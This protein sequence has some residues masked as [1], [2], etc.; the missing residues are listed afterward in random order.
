[1]VLIAAAIAAMSC[2]IQLVGT[3]G[4]GTET[5]PDG[6]TPDAPLGVSE[7]GAAA[8]PDGGVSVADADADAPAC[9]FV[10]IVDP[11]TSLD[12]GDGGWVVARDTSNGDHPKIDPSA[13]GPAVSLI[14]L[15]AVSS[16]GGI[17]RSP[18]DVRAFDMSFRYIITCGALATC[19]DG[20]AAM[21][22]QSRDGGP[23]ELFPSLSGSTFGMPGPG[24]RGGAV[25][26]DVHKDLGTND[27]STPC[28]SI[29]S[30]DP[31][32]SP[33]TYDWHVA[34]TPQDAGLVSAHDVAIRVRKNVVSVSLDGAPL[35]SSAIATTGFVGWVGIGASTGANVGT[36]VIRN[37]DAKFYVCDEP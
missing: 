36:F 11:L 1:M 16:V 5:T 29:L 10:H 9:S 4:T 19:A 21:W 30:I 13:E 27:P 37:F 20:I 24:V 32:K 23:P 25:A 26:I 17:W 31:T 22:V 18:M 33:G 6:G 7:D 3:A 8:L 15:N 2:G 35:L 12:A 28:I 14:S 34:S